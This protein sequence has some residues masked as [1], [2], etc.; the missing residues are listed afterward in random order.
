[1]KIEI[2]NWNWKLTPSPIQCRVRLMVYRRQCSVVQF[3]VILEIRNWNK[4][5]KL[6]IEIKNWNWKLKSKIENW[7]W[8]WKLK[9]EIENLVIEN[10]N[11]KFK[12]IIEIK[13]WNWKLTPSPIQCRETRNKETGPNIR[14]ANHEWAL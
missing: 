3:R 4:K 12:L 6:K 2:K 1:M 10:W 9:I 8:K 11:K 13:N 5:L 7:N 14:I